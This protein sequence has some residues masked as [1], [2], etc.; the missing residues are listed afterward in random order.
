MSSET[1]P[2][3]DEM[4]AKRQSPTLPHGDPRQERAMNATAGVEGRCRL[5]DSGSLQRPLALAIAAA[6][7]FVVANTAPLLSVSVAGRDAATTILG[8][9]Y[10]L[11]RQGYELTAAAVLFCTVLAP[12]GYIVAALSLLLA[13]RQRPAPDWLPRLSKWAGQLHHWAMP[14]VMLLGV[15]VA[16]V[17][18][19]DLAAVTP[20]IGLYAVGALAVL[21]AALPRMFDPR[22]ISARIAGT[23][24]SSRPAT[25]PAAVSAQATWALVLAAAICYVPANALPVLNS[26]SV[27]SSQAQSD[28]ILS[29]IIY[30]FA[31]GSWLLG[32][33]VL[34]ASVMIPIGKLGALAYLLIGARRGSAEQAGER[35]RLLRVVDFIGRWSMLDVFVVA[36]VSALLQLQPLLWAQPGPGL[37]FFAAVVILTMLAARSFD[38]RLIG[39]HG[40]Q[41]GRHG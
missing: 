21:F 39:E 10:G 31:T 36:F 29:G 13:A 30:L 5:A 14:E 41:P 26:Y 27:L 3:F 20:G 18:I 35:S 23:A 12:A 9:A 6:I 32:L 37:P 7:M 4:S 38:P 17:K 25:K 2:P 19:A 28:T 11:W 1:Q 22:G 24:T 33:I 16:L 40:A 8:G 15:L 34:V